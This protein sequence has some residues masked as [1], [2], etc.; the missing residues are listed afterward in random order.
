MDFEALKE[1]YIGKELRTV[2]QF[3]DISPEDAKYFKKVIDE[4]WSPISSLYILLIDE[5]DY[6]AFIDMDCDGYRSGAW[7]VVDLKNWLDNGNTTVMK[8]I[9][10]IIK[11]M[12]YIETTKEECLMITTDEYVIMMG[13]DGTDDYYPSNFF[14]IE[15]AQKHALSNLEGEIVVFK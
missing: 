12:N 9:N 6:L 1:K 3:K 15:E 7:Y 14:N 4:D 2:L 10:S 5:N 8:K 13:Q 11:E